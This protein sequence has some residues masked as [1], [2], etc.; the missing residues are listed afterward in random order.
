MMYPV[1]AGFAFRSAIT[2]SNSSWLVEFG[3]STWIEAIPTSAQSRCLPATYARLPGSSPTSTV[4]RPGRTPRAVSLA[5]RSA[6]STRIAAAVV[7][8]SRITA[9]TH[10]SQEVVVDVLLALVGEERHDVV[11]VELVLEPSRRDD[12]RG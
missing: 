4:P 10:A 8:P 9:A 2:A 3:S 5:T 12:V 11:E 6:S 7:L 1:Q